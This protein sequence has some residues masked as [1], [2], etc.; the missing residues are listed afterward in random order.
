MISRRT[1]AFLVSV[2]YPGLLAAQV[3]ADQAAHVARIEKSLVPAVA[4]MGR[5]VPL[6]TIQERMARFGV[7]GVSIAVVDSG[8][9]LWA[10]GYGVADAAKRTPVTV[11][12]LFQ[13]GPISA[14]VTAAM[15]ALVEAGHLDLDADINTALTSWKLPSYPFDATVTL[16]RIASHTAGLTVSGFPG[17]ARGEKVPTTLGVLRGEGNT[18][19]VIVDVAPGTEWRF[20]S[21]GYMVMQLAMEDVTGTPFVTL[22]DSLV[23]GPLGMT[24]SSYAQPLPEV[25]WEEAASGHDHDGAVMAGAWRVHPELAATGLW[26]TPS[27]LA[28][29]IIEIQRSRRGESSRLLSRTM[30]E[31]MLTPIMNDFGLG[32]AIPRPQPPAPPMNVFISSGPTAGY[33]AM[34]TGFLEHDAGVVI[35]TNGDGGFP[36]IDEILR[37]LAVEY[38]WEGFAVRQVPLVTLSPGRRASIATTYTVEGTPATFTLTWTEEGFL[39]L[40]SELI[41][42]GDL[43]PVDQTT[44]VDGD[45]DRVLR[46]EWDGDRVAR[47]VSRT[48]LVAVPNR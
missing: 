14:P 48:G 22:M 7:P 37:A 42:D 16:R 28:R 8:R 5:P 35:M 15:L 2:A 9:M 40:E 41:L 20:S 26:S 4:V 27:D 30:T 13:A 31:A 38:G 33:R 18:P 6:A 19:P 3:P 34:A 44:L 47:M 10:K 46:V 24:R 1:V 17:Y 39:R 12:T 29:F 36:L 21:G 32:F 25:R 45:N 43:I 11:T 23:L